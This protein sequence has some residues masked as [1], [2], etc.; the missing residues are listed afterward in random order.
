MRSFLS[1]CMLAAALFALSAFAFFPAFGAAAKGTTYR[2]TVPKQGSMNGDANFYAWVPD[3]VPTLRC[4]IVHQHGCTREYDAPQMPTDV[5][6]IQLAKKWNSVFVAPAHVTGSNCGNWNDPSKGS[7][8]VYIAFLDSLARRTSHPEIK[9]IPWALWG[10]SGG[11]GWVTSMTGKYPARVVATIAQACAAEISN[12][13][14]ALKV[15]ILHHNGNKDICYNDSY[16]ANG[17]KKGA[18]WAH[19]INPDPIWESA[20]TAYDPSMEGHAPHDLR[21]LCI[22]W[23]DICMTERLPK[24]AGAAELNDMDTAIAWLGDT[25]TRAIAP[26]ASYSGNKLIACWFPNQTIAIKWKE[27]MIK[28]TIYDS[29]PPPAPYNLTG[30]YANRQIALKWDCDADLESGIKT[31]IIYR[32]GAIAQT[33]QYN[34]TTLFTLAKGFQRWNDGDQPV[35][36]P[37]PAMTFTDANLN[38][39]ATYVYQICCVNWSDVAGAKSEV[40]TLKGG[41]VT[42]VKGL[43]VTQASTTPFSRCFNLVYCTLRLSAGAVDIYDI[44]GRLLKSVEMKT[45]GSIDAKALL[46]NGGADKMVVVRYR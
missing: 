26:A 14:A 32:N 18:L 29:T 27:Y 37:A 9:T 10:H 21:M 28:G 6:W 2:I 38:D 25:A 13:P 43:H 5:Q 15:P 7:D 33:L 3:S 41:K 44:R 17:R 16:F 46:G 8:A 30:T 12:I 4:V 23:L 40:L 39:T 34:T 19:A 11:A 45:A 36:S 1:A 24:Q 35:P 42:A 22:P 20:P 31:F